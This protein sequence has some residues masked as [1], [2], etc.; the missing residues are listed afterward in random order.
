VRAGWLAFEVGGRHE[1][2]HPEEALA[3]YRSL[4]ETLEGLPAWRRLGTAVLL[5][6]V[7]RREQVLG[8]R[9]AASADH[10]DV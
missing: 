7:R 5:D 6:E 3:L 9:D 1:S 8:A 10:G 2:R 4:R